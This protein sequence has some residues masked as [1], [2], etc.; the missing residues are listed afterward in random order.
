[1]CAHTQCVVMHTS[2]EC[3]GVSLCV[4]DGVQ[5]STHRDGQHV[6]VILAHS[7]SKGLYLRAH[8]GPLLHVHL[9]AGQV[10]KLLQHLL[11]R[12]VLLHTG[13]RLTDQATSCLL[14]LVYVGHGDLPASSGP[15]FASSCQNCSKS[16]NTRTHHCI[17]GCNQMMLCK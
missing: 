10:H 5:G 1:M 9:L 14:S 4:A 17:L 11:S 16:V 7:S 2:A 13:V 12:V 15:E 8:Q 6:H 3:C